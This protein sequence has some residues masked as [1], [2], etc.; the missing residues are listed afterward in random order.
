MFVRKTLHFWVDLVLASNLILGPAFI[1][2]LPL[3]PSLPPSLSLSHFLSLSLPF[4]LCLPPSLSFNLPLFLD[5]SSSNFPDFIRHVSQWWEREA[6]CAGFGRAVL[7][8]AWPARSAP[9]LRY[10]SP[11]LGSVAERASSWHGLSEQEP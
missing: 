4:P 1:F 5:T 6:L 10:W 11:P 8:L 3:S 2:H 9:P 7:C